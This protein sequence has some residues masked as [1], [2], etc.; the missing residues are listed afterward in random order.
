MTFFHAALSKM[1]LEVCNPHMADFRGEKNAKS[2]AVII[3]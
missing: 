3:R 1:A 2:L